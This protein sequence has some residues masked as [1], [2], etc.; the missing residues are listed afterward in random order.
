MDKLDMTRR[1]K[2][3]VQ[4]AYR[5]SKSAAAVSRDSGTMWGGQVTEELN[6]RATK[7]THHL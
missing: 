6:Q 5:L 2:D 7:A 1:G 4:R 3:L